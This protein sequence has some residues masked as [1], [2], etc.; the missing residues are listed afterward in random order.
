MAEI[1]L[2]GKYARGRKALCDDADYAL[3]S[4]HRW[5]VTPKGYARTSLPQV[6]GQPRYALMHHLLRDARGGGFVDHINGDR[7]DNQR[8]N[9]RPASHTENNR[10]R[11]RHKNN[12]CGYKGVC[13]SKGKWR[14]T[15]HLGRKQIHLGVYKHPLIAAVAYNA[16]A[17][18]LYGPFAQL[19]DLTGLDELLQQEVARAG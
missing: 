4:L 10:N 9:L 8:A 12:K 7:L 15:I 2:H 16:A 6:E 17:I 14:A 11:R 1:A 5:H 3:L 13:A 19:N 18:A